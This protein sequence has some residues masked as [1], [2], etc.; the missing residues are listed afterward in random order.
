MAASLCTLA[1][2]SDK[3]VPGKFKI[4][5][6]DVPGTPSGLGYLGV[7]NINDWGTVVGYSNAAPEIG[8]IRQ[9]NGTI[10]DLADPLSNGSFQLTQ[11]DGINNEGTIVGY[12][13]D[14]AHDEYSGFLYQKGTFTTYNFPGL[15]QY[16]D[17][18]ILGIN[19]FGAFVGFYEVPPAYA[20]V[21]FANFNGHIDTNFTIAGSILTEPIAI[22]DLGEVAGIYE[23]SSDVYH[24]FFRD[25]KGK[26]TTID[27]PG[28]AA[29]GSEV[30]GLNNF[31]WMSGHF[32]DADSHEHGFVRSPDGDFFQIDVPKANITTPNAGT[33][34][35]GVND[36]GVVAG[37]YD[38][39]NGAVEQ[40]YIAVP[41]FDRGC[42]DHGH[43]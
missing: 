12:Y 10:T 6:F 18:A 32:W 41:E 25:L 37:H 1:H 22:N 4:T 33:A 2:A 34:G 28:A 30:L 26:I 31:G 11:A 27:V 42:Q 9:P 14:T 21:P 35:G 13:F 5:T 36:F 40:G 24:G 23:D 19:D 15:P 8:F 39:D 43:K 38:P 29:P 16:S 7:E 3:I 17:T 20:V